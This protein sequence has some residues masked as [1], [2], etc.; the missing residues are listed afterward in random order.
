MD[1]NNRL[2]QSYLL[3]S[4]KYRVVHALQRCTAL[5]LNDMKHWKKTAFSLFIKGQILNFFLKEGYS[6]LESNSDAFVGQPSAWYSYMSVRIYRMQ[7]DSNQLS[8]TLR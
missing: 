3:E 7:Y 6:G 2:L 4:I 1:I 5:E 8:S